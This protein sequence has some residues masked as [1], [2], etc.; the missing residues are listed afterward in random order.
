MALSAMRTQNEK[1]QVVSHDSF[2]EFVAKLTP[3]ERHQLAADVGRVRPRGG[4]PH[5]PGPG[6][7][8]K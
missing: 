6:P 5:G 1:L 2:V 3:E 7:I 4:G 8:R